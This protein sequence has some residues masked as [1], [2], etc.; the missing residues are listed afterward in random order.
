MFSAHAECDPAAGQTTLT[1]EV[2]NNGSAPVQITNLTEPVTLEPNPVPPGATA[3]ATRVIDGPATDEQVTSTVTVDVGG[4]VVTELSDE[5][6]AGACEGPEVPPDIGFELS[7][8]PSV[9]QAAVGDTVEYVY[10]ARNTS[11]I[12]LAE[13]RLVD[14]RIGVVLEGE[15][16]IAPGATVC[17]TD[18]GAP[19]S[20]VV[21][22]SDAGSVIRNNAV[23]TVQTQEAQSR[24]FQAT[25]QASVAVVPDVITVPPLI[26]RAGGFTIQKTVDP[27]TVVADSDI[28]YEIVIGF[29]GQTPGEPFT[30]TDAVPAELTNVSGACG[31]V[32]QATC[33][34]TGSGNAQSW[35]INPLAPGGTVRLSISAHVPADLP[36][37]T[38]VHNTAVINGDVL[39]ASNTFTII[40][41]IPPVPTVVPETPVIVP[42]YCDDNNK[43]VPPTIQLPHT[44]GITYT[45]APPIPN[46][47]PTLEAARGF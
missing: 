35:S 38:A 18:V 45:V 43:P 5:I 37:G 41:E 29:S 47:I 44:E 13:L 25:A 7:V 27:T 14:D 36:V 39:T 12:P 33:V 10:C 34:N 31:A 30:V 46:P 23:V 17:N 20:Y 9:T 28:T 22:P 2:T 16:P 40:D 8:T 4:G 3:T 19:A 32:S 21:R 42:G 1:W 24:A 15:E 26:V 6:T 11:T